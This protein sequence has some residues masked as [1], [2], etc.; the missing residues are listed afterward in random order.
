M[1]NVDSA[2]TIRRPNWQPPDDPDRVP[3]SSVVYYARRANGDIKIGTTSSGVKDRLKQL[4]R[5]HGQLAL[6]AVEDGGFD[7]EFARHVE[8]A[9]DRVGGEWFIPT[10][11]LLRLIASLGGAA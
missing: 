3:W 9:D 4:A 10:P 11:A 5:R 1:S 8:F 7:Q 2:A 6:L